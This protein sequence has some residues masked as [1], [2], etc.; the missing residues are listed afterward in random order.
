[1][2]EVASIN[3]TNSYSRVA[4]TL[5]SLSILARMSWDNREYGWRWGRKHQSLGIPGP[6]GTNSRTGKTET[7]RIVDLPDTAIG[8]E[9]QDDSLVESKP[10]ETISPGKG[11]GKEIPKTGRASQQI[12]RMYEAD[13]E[14]QEAAETSISLFEAYQ[15]TK[16]EDILK[17]A[18]ELAR[19][20]MKV[21]LD[22]PDLDARRISLSVMEEELKRKPLP[23]V[24]PGDFQKIRRALCIAGS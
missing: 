6:S 11:K 17:E 13:D 9:Y 18:I 12:T 19:T 2:V 24:S 15:E 22:H 5:L 1:L 10:D 21:P 16:D 7:Q 20:A 14:A 8:L 3:T 23:L 4:K